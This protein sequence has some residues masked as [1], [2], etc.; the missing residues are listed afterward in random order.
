MLG[1]LWVGEN[2]LGELEPVFVL[3]LFIA[4]LKHIEIK[5]RHLGVDK[6]RLR[7]RRRH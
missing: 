7:E 2:L 4:F 1:E 5:M 3:F 6:G